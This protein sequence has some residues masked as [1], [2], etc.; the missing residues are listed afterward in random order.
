MSAAATTAA[1]APVVRPARRRLRAAGDLCGLLLGGLAL[2]HATHAKA[3]KTPSAAEL[4]IHDQA[5]AMLGT[6]YGFGRDDDEA[7]DCSALMRRIF[8]SAGIALPRTT[9]QLLHTGVPVPRTQPRAGDLL[10]YRWQRHQLHV[11]L[12]LDRQHI[13]HASPSAGE[14]VVTPLDAAWQRRLVT[15][16]RVLKS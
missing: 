7:V 6:G 9:H 2:L 5:L 16:R 13:V 12:M 1:Q 14:V 4:Q 11:A 15:V 3:A 8:A 10:I